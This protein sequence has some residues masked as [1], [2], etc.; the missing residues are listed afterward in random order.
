MLA[1]VAL[2]RAGI[3]GNELH[4]QADLV[5]EVDEMAFALAAFVGG[6]HPAQLEALLGLVGHLPAPFL[7]D[8]V[9]VGG[10]V[11]RRE[12]VVGA[13]GGQ[14]EG[15][16]EE[17]VGRQRAAS[18]E[19]QLVEDAV[20]QLPGLGPIEQLRVGVEVELEGVVGD[21]H[22]AEGVVG[23]DGDV[24]VGAQAL[25]HLLLEVEGG[26]VGE[27]E[28]QDLVGLGVALL[29]QPQDALGHH[30][31]LARTRSGHEEDGGEREGDG[32]A[33]LRRRS[34]RALRHRVRSPGPGAGSDTDG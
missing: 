27:G 15:V 28:G 10:H 3:A 30:R 19:A 5:A 11:V 31:R 2:G 12:E 20:E 16:V 4:G 34:E 7:H 24:G 9:A 21:E 26:L 18:V 1:A 22:G 23:G 6:H 32:G 13:A 17:D 33:L 14:G 8:A 29:D 25:A